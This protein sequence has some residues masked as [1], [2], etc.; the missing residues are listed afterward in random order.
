MPSV[1]A[2]QFN[3]FLGHNRWPKAEYTFSGPK[4]KPTACDTF[5][6]G[7]YG[8]ARCTRIYGKNGDQISYFI[9]PNSFYKE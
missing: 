6:N 5:Y 9:E 1:D 2:I 3:K 4:H 8:T 7:P